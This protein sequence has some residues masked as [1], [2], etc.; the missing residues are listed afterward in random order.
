MAWLV[1]AM[2]VIANHFGGPGNALGLLFVS[3]CYVHVMTFLIND[4]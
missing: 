2:S 4:L 3:L 1:P